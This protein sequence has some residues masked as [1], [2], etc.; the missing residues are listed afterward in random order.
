[1]Y[2]SVATEG[3]VVP[4]RARMKL[5]Y[6]GQKQFN[7]TLG[8]NQYYSFN[9]NSFFDPDG[10][11]GGG[12]PVGFDQWSAFYNYYRVRAC[13]F[14]C[15]IIQAS[16]TAANVTQL[17]LL[18]TSDTS[19]TTSQSIIV[20]AQQPYAKTRFTN[21]QSG[22]GGVVTLKSYMSTKRILGLTKAMTDGDDQLQ[23]IVSTNPA[24]VWYWVVG[25]V[26]LD[27]TST[28]NAYMDFTMTMYGEFYSRKPLAAS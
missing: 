16:S 14:K 20:N 12:Q 10:A 27:G 22:S 1:M 5:R 23:A 25:S 26:A 28:L 8:G 21:V 17:I 11:V 18:P 9:A 19:G 2:K 6:F 4:D 3:M 13:K 24:R 15:T 7:I